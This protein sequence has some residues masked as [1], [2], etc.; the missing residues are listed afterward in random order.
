MYKANLSYEGLKNYL[1][2]LVEGGLLKIDENR[3]SVRTY[4]VTRKG[5]ELLEH[6]NAMRDLLG[7]SP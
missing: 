2:M 1:T 3:D 7:D 5:L 4:T 6:A